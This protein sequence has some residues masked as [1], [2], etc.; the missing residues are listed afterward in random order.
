[1]FSHAIRGTNN[2]MLGNCKHAI[3]GMRKV[4]KLFPEVDFYI[5]AV[6]DLALQILYKKGVLKEKDILDAD[7][8]ILHNCHGYMFYHFDDSSGGEIERAEAIKVGMIEDHEHDIYFDL[9]KASYLVIRKS[10]SPI[11]IE[12]IKRFRGDK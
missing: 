10:I 1:M 8:E 9:S 4:Q 5:P 3:A 6:G 7:L 11:V 2:D 12:T